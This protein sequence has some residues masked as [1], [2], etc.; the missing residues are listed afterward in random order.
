MIKNKQKI[1]NFF[2]YNVVKNEMYTIIKKRLNS[3]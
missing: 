2:N 1:D 3:I